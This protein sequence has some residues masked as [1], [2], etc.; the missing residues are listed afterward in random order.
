MRLFISPKEFI[1]RKWLLLHPVELG[2]REKQPAALHKS[3]NEP[4][5]ALGTTAGW[6]PILLQVPLYYI[7]ALAI[8]VKQSLLTL[9]GNVYFI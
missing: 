6:T 9:R 5:R 7:T 8:V 3:A 2:P 1:R 4:V